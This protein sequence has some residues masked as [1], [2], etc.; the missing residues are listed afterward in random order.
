MLRSSDLSPT[1]WVIM[2]ITNFVGLIS[3]V[4]CDGGFVWDLL[5]EFSKHSQE[6][7]K[8]II[9]YMYIISNGYF[10]D[11]FSVHFHRCCHHIQ[12]I[13]LYPTVPK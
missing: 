3:G 8:H 12:G 13:D 10:S 9:L 2:P 5:Q 6:F 4:S 1:T 11:D 7:P